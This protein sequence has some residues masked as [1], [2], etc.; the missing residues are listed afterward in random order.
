MFINSIEINADEY[1]QGQISHLHVQIN[2]LKDGLHD[3]KKSYCN[4]EAVLTKEHSCKKDPEQELKDLKS[5]LQSEANTSVL[6]PVTV[7]TVGPTP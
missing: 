1:I 2:E 7:V 5:C 6:P 4:P 3:M